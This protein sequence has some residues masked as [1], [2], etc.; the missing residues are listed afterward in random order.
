MNGEIW[1]LKHA[2][3]PDQYVW[4]DTK[5]K[6]K[7][8]GWVANPQSLQ[9]M[10]FAGHPGIG[11]TT[12]AEMLA[13]ELGLE[14]NLDYVLFRV[15]MKPASELIDEIKN[16]CESGF[17]PLKIIILDEADKLTTGAQE[18]MRGITDLYETMGCRFILTCNDAG[19]LKN[20]MG[21]RIILIEFTKLDEE[22]FFERMIEIAMLEG[23][24]VEN[25]STFEILEKIK[26]QTYPDLRQ[27][28]NLMQDGSKEDKIIEVGKAVTERPWHLQMIEAI[29]NFNIAVLREDL[30]GLRKD[31]IASAYKFLANNSDIFE[32]NEGDAIVLIAKYLYWH[33]SSEYPD[34]NLCGLM[35]EL[36]RLWKSK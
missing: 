19:K 17:S 32:E 23:I 26:N 34:V 3:L 35:V 4:S 8:D 13:K 27:A 24:D 2:P 14:K 30:Q 11:K 6:D 20:Y 21:S 16:F 9:H 31:E 33:S 12:L 15:G 25:E 28:I 1:R 29:G 36:S 22:R 7:F 10:V 5:L 18:T